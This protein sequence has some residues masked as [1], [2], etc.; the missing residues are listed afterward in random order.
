LKQHGKETNETETVLFL[1]S[2]SLNRNE[3]ARND[4]S[5]SA[6]D[7]YARDGAIWRIR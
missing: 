6:Y 7:Y 5:K 3:R 2:F 4:D 1:G